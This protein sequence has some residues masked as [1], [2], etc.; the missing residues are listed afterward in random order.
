MRL[1]RAPAAALILLAGAELAQAHTIIPGVDGFRGGLLHPFLVPEQ[2]LALFAMA[3]M[4]GQQSEHRLALISVFPLALIASMGLIALAYSASAPGMWLLAT[5]FLSGIAVAAAQR[6]PLA[7]GGP[8]VVAT[9]AALLFDSVPQSVSVRETLLSLSGTALSAF[10][11]AVCVVR[12]VELLQRDWQ[13]IG[14]RIVGSW[15][16][17]TAL[18]VLAMRLKG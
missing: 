3:L 8:L 10:L 5:A 1:A 16:A 17:A 18:L 6:L 9:A 15:M 4:I 14:I 7:L 11:A 2:A 13:R 12:L